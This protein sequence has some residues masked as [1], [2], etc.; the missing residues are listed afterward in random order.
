MNAIH[1]LYRR[2]TTVA[3]AL[4]ATASWADGLH[5]SVRTL[6]TRQQMPVANVRCVFQDS[7]GMMW[8]GTQGGG[9][10]RDN[11]YQ[12]NTFRSDAR[13]P[14][15]LADNYVHCIAEDGRGRVW[16]G[17]G[18]QLYTIDKHTLQLRKQAVGERIAALK[19]DSKGRLWVGAQG[20]VYCIDTKTDAVVL[21][22]TS[23][24]LRGASQFLED[25][26]HRVWV[27]TWG[28]TPSRY[29]ES[30]RRL[31]TQ[32]WHCP[33]GV[34]A[35]A[36]DVAAGG[37]W[38]ATWG[39]GVVFY[40]AKTGE[41]I[42]QEATLGTD[43]KQKCIDILLDRTQGLLW[44]TTLDNLYLYRREGRR[45][46]E[47]QTSA[48]LPVGRK[49]VDH[50][51]EDR[52]GNVWVASFTP[53]TFIVSPRKQSLTRIDVPQMAQ[54]TG[55]PL[56]PDRMVA[57]ASG[58]QYWIWQGR[59]GLMHYDAASGRL[60]DI[61]GD[62][63]RCI[64]KCSQGVGLWA[65]SRRTLLK[66]EKVQPAPLT[67]VV[68]ECEADFDN[69]ITFIADEQGQDI[70]VGTRLALYRYYPAT[71]N[72]AR[73]CTTPEPVLD[74]TEAADGTAYLLT[75][76]R[77]MRC[78]DK[79]DTLAVGIG[80]NFTALALAPDGRLYVATQQGSLYTLADDGKT[81]VRDERMSNANGDAII[82]VATDLAGHV[83]LLS[84]QYVREF[85]PFTYAFRTLRSG[86]AD[87]DVSYF[88]KLENVG[89][90][91]M[92]LCG[93]GAYCQVESSPM[94]DRKHPQGARTVVT[95][96]GMDDSLRL[97]DGELR[98]V[99]V[100]ACTSSV[101]LYCSTLEH[102]DAAKVAY[103]YRLDGGDWVYLP[104]GVN[105]V[106]L[107]RLP[108]GVTRVM[109]KAT[110]RY[111]CWSPV[112][113]ELT[114]DRLP[115]WWETWWAYCLYLALAVGVAYGLWRLNRR[116]RY[117][118]A[119]QRHRK[120]LALTEVEV[121]VEELEKGDGRAD[122]FLKKAVA[123][124]EAHLA[125]TEYSVE[126][127]SSDMCM[128]RMSLYRKMQAVTG[129]SP[130]EFIRDI[131]LKN[132]ASILRRHPGMTATQV[133]ARVGFATPKYFSKCFKEK[134]GASPSQYAAAGH[135]ETKQENQI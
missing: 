4:C 125:D 37:Y 135:D 87:I 26:Q 99:E 46:V 94:L 41:T 124:V 77:L 24:L 114:I 18:K 103:A 43:D 2:L 78:K 74:A 59:M 27:A 110:D 23:Q 54:R 133:A 68:M 73:L 108:K 6:P 17:T 63:A 122:D 44:V 31:E 116:I 91:R 29:S 7:E 3:L 9:L 5:F 123:L 97:C 19:L 96:I 130:N 25:S 22:D 109:L 90:K 104:Q 112:E 32:P 38:A 66:I 64:A 70:L 51:C 33:Y 34:E 120:T 49:I 50:L 113:T 115:E 86:D 62:Y 107:S 45:L 117:M 39:G 105:T 53:N 79:A 92:G 98:E 52:A 85:H 88:Y 11:G 40:D 84:N 56:L 55:F 95:A 47:V 15:L 16:F 8:Y 75:S 126:A 83:W 127:F 129:L 134:F 28:K 93:A 60:T 69:T 71:G 10:C 30:R 48:F 82:D 13:T 20:G 121:K 100:E 21:R 132:A 12:V 102:L 76:N 118:L 67:T 14:G 128:S 89:D 72:V 42:P 61:P 36:E 131:R 119:L 1:L 58:S 35:M 111:G 57:E 81:L 80:E 106:Y 65:A 101:V